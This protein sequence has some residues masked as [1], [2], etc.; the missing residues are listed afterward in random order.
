MEV[1]AAK[2]KVKVVVVMTTK[3]T[4]TMTAA[5]AHG[6][7]GDVTDTTTG[8]AAALP[9]AVEDVMAA[10]ARETH[11]DRHRPTQGTAIILSR[12]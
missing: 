3:A 12:K 10:G 5:M 2:K 1:K 6:R 8:K 9:G 11:G 7:T 4:E